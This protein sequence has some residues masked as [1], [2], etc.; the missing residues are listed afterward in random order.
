[1]TGFEPLPPDAPSLRW[2]FSGS[3][4][5]NDDERLA[6]TLRAILPAEYIPKSLRPYSRT[7]FQ[8]FSATGYRYRRKGDERWLYFSFVANLTPPPGRPIPGV[9]FVKGYVG[10]TERIASRDDVYM[11]AKQHMRA[12]FVGRPDDYAATK[13]IADKAEIQSLAR[14][15]PGA[16]AVT[17]ADLRRLPRTFKIDNFTSHTYLRGGLVTILD[18]RTSR[19]MYGIGFRYI[20]VPYDSDD[21]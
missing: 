8:N 9:C 19:T 20:P 6:T 16:P 11:V 3:L 4:E 7:S 1:M 15:L 12:A 14:Q 13:S 2:I 10:N 5:R 18:G 17:D 21:E